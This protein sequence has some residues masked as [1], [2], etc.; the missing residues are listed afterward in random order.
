MRLIPV[1]DLMRGQA[2]RAVRG[3]RST[4]LPLRSQLCVGAEP[5]VV[6]RALLNHCQG[7]TLYVADLDSLQGGEVQV[8]VL[9]AL[10]LQLPQCALWLDAGFADRDAADRLLAGMGDLASR[11]TPVYASES[12]RN[13]EALQGLFDAADAEGPVLSLDRR[14]GV[15]LDAAAAWRTPAAWPRRVIVMT[16]ERVGAGSGPDLDTLAQVQALS[17]KAHLIGAGGVRCMADLLAAR[18]AGAHAWLVASALH[19]GSIGAGEL[20]D[21][22]RQARVSP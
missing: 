7:R 9:T 21:F 3:E 5:E 1:I 8:A 6:A 14:H 4:Y 2:V 15:R 10:M 17:P 22:Q 20:A 18:A 12:L 13:P 19:D 11:V 16:L